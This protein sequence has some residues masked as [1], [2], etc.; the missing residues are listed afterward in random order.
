MLF[1]KVILIGFVIRIE[2]GTSRSPR[3]LSKSDYDLLMKC[4]SENK[5]SMTSKYDAQTKRVYRL[6]KSGNYKLKQI[7]DPITGKEE[8]KIVSKIE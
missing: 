2:C 4:L 3:P 7:D 8:T 5:L 6:W 1:F